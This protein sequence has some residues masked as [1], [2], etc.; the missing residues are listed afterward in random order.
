[1]AVTT[2]PGDRDDR[3]REHS[4][5]ELLSAL[6]DGEVDET[7]IDQGCRRWRD[8]PGTRQDW[9]AFHLIGDVMRSDELAQPT[10]RSQQ[11][12]QAF[13]ERLEAE[14]VVL[15]PVPMAL[16]TPA[17]A[18]IATNTA[19]LVRGRRV[20]GRAWATSAAV[21]AGVM[22]VGGLTWMLNPQ[23]LNGGAGSTLASNPAPTALPGTTAVVPV[24]AEVTP[25]AGNGFVVRP[26]VYDP[27]IAAHRELGALSPIT[28]SR[29][30]VTTPSTAMAGAAR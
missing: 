7:G 15:A 22:V 10:A 6:M 27:Y 21:A 28:E 23:L 4:M 20:R 14:P 3:S 26:A 1:M 8:E 17:S 24:S 9:M 5:R 25:P 2:N 16:G 30:L 12:L 19:S 13:H 11:F 18:S 29:D